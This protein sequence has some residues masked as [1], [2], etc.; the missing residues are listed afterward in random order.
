[1]P[2]RSRGSTHRD[3]VMITGDGVECLRICRA[4]I[5]RNIT[6]WASYLP[7]SWLVSYCA[8]LCWLWYLSPLYCSS[9]TV[10]YSTMNRSLFF[11]AVALFIWGV[12][13]GMFSSFNPVYLQ[14]LGGSN[15]RSHLG[16]SRCLWPLSTC[17]PA[18]SD[19]Y[20]ATLLWG[21]DFRYRLRGS[22][23]WRTLYLPSF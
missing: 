8:S 13:E 6:I 12:G 9:R 7:S 15:N 18:I 1:M 21:A 2:D 3:N 22:W 17:L 5:H 23:P 14:E 19:H 16:R 4:Q 11:L 10:D 20:I